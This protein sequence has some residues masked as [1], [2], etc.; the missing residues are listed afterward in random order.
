MAE[1]KIQIILADDHSLVRD[2]IKS[3]L[4]ENEDLQVIAEASNGEEA[5]DLVSALSPDLLIVD[6]RMPVLNGIQTVARLKKEHPKVK[7]LVLSMHDS[8]E[9]VLQSVEAGAYGY[10]LKD[11]SRDEFIKAIY[12][13]NSGEKYF[14]GDISTIIV[15][16]YLENING[17]SQPTPTEN[18]QIT[19]TPRIKLTKRQTQILNLAISGM[20]NK[21][22]ADHIGKS[23]RTVEAH[24]F[25]LMK[26][27][28]VKNLAELSNKAKALGLIS[29]A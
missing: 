28:G 3:L 17:T 23:I 16:K 15:K 25:S 9:Y 6:I 26:K 13:I 2:G 12:T 19:N 7:S 5:I 29:Q 1:D 18:A 20:S 27:L 11:N 22:I 21:E 14:S 24:R 10:L 8:E 4:Q